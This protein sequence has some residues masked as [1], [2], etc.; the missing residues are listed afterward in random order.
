MIC[1]FN[2]QVLQK[3]PLECYFPMALNLLFSNCLL[4][5]KLLLEPSTYFT[6]T[7]RNFAII[8]CRRFLMPGSEI[9]FQLPVQG[10]IRTIHYNFIFIQRGLDS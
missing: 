1:C 6:I 4:L 2:T 9:K 10:P 7:S 8:F 3:K 5:S